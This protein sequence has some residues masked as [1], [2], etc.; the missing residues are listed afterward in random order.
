MKIAI[1]I[2]APWVRG[3]IDVFVYIRELTCLGHEPIV[4]CR[5]RSEFVADVPVYVASAAELCDS[6][7][8]A[9]HRLDI[10]IV[11]SWLHDSA[12]TRALKDS[13]VYVVQR[14]DTD[15][16]INVRSFPAASL[17]KSVIIE[18]GP[19]IAVRCFKHWLK[20]YI[21]LHKEEAAD[22]LSCIEQADLTA[23]ETDEA[24]TNLTKFLADYGRTDLIERIRVVPHFVSER[25]GRRVLPSVKR[26]KVV[27][28]G[29]WSEPQ[30]NAALLASTIRRYLKL[31]SS[32]EFIIVG[33]GGESVFGPLRKTLPQ[34]SYI[35]ATPHDKVSELLADCQIFF[36][37]ARWEGQSIA[38]L[39]ALAMGCSIVATPIPGFIDICKHPDCGTV[40]RG[41][42]S[43]HLADALLQEMTAWREGRRDHRKI[44]ESWRL[45]HEPHDVIQSLIKTGREI[46]QDGLLFDVTGQ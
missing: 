26:R 46:R 21:W 27:S 6:Q 1:V 12:V 11:F 37:A 29:R 39:E 43:T 24:R 20:R 16:Q 9:P 31:D 5:D 23:V 42:S 36:S 8:Y 17:R 28:I 15:G 40:S 33:D 32:V 19:F 14:S 41:H 4:I 30:K 18:S 35:G 22:S 25:F 7:F 38:A 34:V 2:V 10:A 45:R 3:S 44:S 13:K